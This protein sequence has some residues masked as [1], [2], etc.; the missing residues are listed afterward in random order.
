MVPD[1]FF[2]KPVCAESCTVF[3]NFQPLNLA[4]TNNE[5]LREKGLCKLKFVFFI[6]IT[7]KSKILVSNFYKEINFKPVSKL[8]D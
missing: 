1:F 5:K 3:L 7:L 2:I 8:E 6:V 4:Q